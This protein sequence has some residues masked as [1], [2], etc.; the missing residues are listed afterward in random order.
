MVCPS[1]S[2]SRAPSPFEPVPGYEA[3]PHAKSTLGASNTS[4][5][6]RTPMTLPFSV[7]TSFTLPCRIS[8]RHF[9]SFFQSASAM[10]CALSETG[11]TRLPRSVFSGT[12]SPSKKSIVSCGVKWFTAP[13]KNR[14]LP[15]VDSITVRGSQLFVTLQRPLPVMRI[16]RPSC[17]FF[18]NNRTCLPRS[19][20]VIAAIMPAAPPPTT[21]ASNITFLV[22]LVFD[23]LVHAVLVP[24]GLQV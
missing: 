9:F 1:F 19:A 18:S 4:F 22:G 13:Y 5:S 24:N 2:A 6:V 3:P 15:G 10:S 14:P 12:P 17:A 11:N 21:T 7:S 16:F 8:T 23:L 20:A